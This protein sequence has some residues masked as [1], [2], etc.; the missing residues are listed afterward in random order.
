VGHIAHPVE[1]Q[2]G[3]VAGSARGGTEPSSRVVRE[4]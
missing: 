4:H 3:V 1:E 2:A